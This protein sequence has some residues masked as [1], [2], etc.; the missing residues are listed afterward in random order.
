M[1]VDVD[2]DVDVNVNVNVD[3]D[4]DVEVDGDRNGDW[5]EDED[6]SRRSNTTDALL[7]PTAQCL[8][9]TARYLLIVT[10]TYY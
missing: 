6:L 4:V 7:L 9:V 8:P 1:D 3:V 5:K 10:P 2:V